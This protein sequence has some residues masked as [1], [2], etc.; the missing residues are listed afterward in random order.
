MLLAQFG[1][2]RLSLSNVI[3]GCSLNGFSNSI[4]TE[5]QKFCGSFSGFS[6]KE[7]SEALKLSRNGALIAV[8]AHSKIF[9]M[10]IIVGNL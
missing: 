5:S 1:E 4:A 3:S 9:M 6:L 8:A 2:S 10:W 7:T